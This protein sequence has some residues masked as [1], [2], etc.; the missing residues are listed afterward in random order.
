MF[1]K[2][3]L[4]LP[5]APL[6]LAVGLMG[7]PAAMAD[8]IACPDS[9]SGAI[10]SSDGSSLEAGITKILQMPVGTTVPNATFNFQAAKVSADGDTTSAGL[11]TMPGLVAAGLTVSSAPG[12]VGTTVGTVTTYVYNLA[13]V[14]PDANL[15]PHAGVF[16]YTITEAGIGTN[17]AIEADSTHQKLTYSSAQYTVTLYVDNVPAPGNGLYISAIGAMKDYD[18][19]GDPVGAKVDPTPGGDGDASGLAFTNTYLKTGATTDPTTDAPL[20]ISKAVTGSLANTEQYFDFAMVLTPNILDVTAP[21]AYKAYVVQAGVVVTDAANGTIAGT[22]AAGAYIM[23]SADGVNTTS[24]ALKDG[25]AL[26]FVDTAVGTAYTVQEINPTGYTPSYSVVTAGSIAPRVAGVTGASLGTG[27]QLVGDGTSATDF[28]NAR[29]LI[30]PTGLTMNTLPFV[31]FIALALLALAGYIAV[32][33]RG[34]KVGAR[35]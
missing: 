28:S 13:N 26:V 21:A 8:P 16:V 14:L 9:A 32:T 22:D 24:F 2:T 20:S 19:A 33:A 4:L 17:P 11:A 15:Y 31:G 35:S 30:T 10:C 6:A 3:K 23:V 7:A 1:K 29:S 18:D 12:D 27:S 34:R 25:Q 5:L